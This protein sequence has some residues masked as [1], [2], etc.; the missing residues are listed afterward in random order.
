M[1]STKMDKRGQILTGPL[2][3]TVSIVLALFFIGV[4]IFAFVLA[5][6][7]IRGATT[8][9]DAETVINQS[10]EGASKFASFSPALW[11]MAG[12]GALITIILLAVAGFV[13][14]A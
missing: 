5:G 3:V 12:V 8:D 14:R 11:I 7:E 9:V 13:M 4:L 2:G 6:S 1:V 10:I